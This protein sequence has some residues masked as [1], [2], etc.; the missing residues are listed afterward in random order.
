[1]SAWSCLGFEAH[2]DA[3]DAPLAVHGPT[4]P[5]QWPI[6]LCPQ[7]HAKSQT[8]PVLS[9]SSQPSSLMNQTLKL[10][11]GRQGGWWQA[12]LAWRARTSNIGMLTRNHHKLKSTKSICFPMP[13]RIL[14]AHF[15]NLNGR[16]VLSSQACKA[17]RPTTQPRAKTATLLIE[18]S[19]PHTLT[20]S[21]HH[22][23]LFFSV[24]VAHLKRQVS[25]RRRSRAISITTKHHPHHG[26]FRLLFASR[27][28]IHPPH[29]S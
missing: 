7:T 15:C 16:G 9:T 2:G 29:A 20:A 22:P 10:L 19:K 13:S 27:Y 4:F 17:P 24:P 26:R 28:P 25:L 18:M 14:R 21:R 3:E 1:M 23:P 8:V 11:N 6:I 12:C 5:E